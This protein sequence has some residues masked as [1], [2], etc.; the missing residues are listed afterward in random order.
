MCSPN[1][2]KGVLNSNAPILHSN[3]AE[4]SHFSNSMCILIEYFS[5]GGLSVVT[6]DVYCGMSQHSGGCSTSQMVN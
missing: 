3:C 4:G 1:A 2:R 6:F 5:L